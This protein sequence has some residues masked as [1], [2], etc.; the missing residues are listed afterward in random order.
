LDYKSNRTS[1]CLDCICL[2]ILAVRTQ[3]DR[4]NLM[5]TI[6]RKCREERWYTIR[7]VFTKEKV[8]I[9]N[10]LK[11]FFRRKNLT[12]IDLGVNYIMLFRIVQES[13]K[14]RAKALKKESE[15]IKLPEKKITSK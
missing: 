12:L 11:D 1:L 8:T 2:R 7:K 14:E 3:K 15:T 6:E 4:A 5:E 9:S 10:L 13:L